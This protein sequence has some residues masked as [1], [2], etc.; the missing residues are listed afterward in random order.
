MP[1]SDCTD[2]VDIA[3]GLAFPFPFPFTGELSGS[4]VVGV[5]LYKGVSEGVDSVTNT[6]L[7]LGVVMTLILDD[8]VTS[9][10]A[11]VTRVIGL[12]KAGPSSLKI[13]RKK[14]SA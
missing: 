7:V 12:R 14:Y 2:G 9:T 4:T 11:V 6:F 10:G 5:P 13:V 3:F 1:G 8:G